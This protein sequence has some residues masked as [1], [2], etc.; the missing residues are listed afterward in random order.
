MILHKIESPFNVHIPT[1]TVPSQK[2]H[3]YIF[4]PYLNQALWMEHAAWWLTSL[5]RSF[6]AWPKFSMQIW[7]NDAKL[8]AINRWKRLK[9]CCE[10]RRNQQPWSNSDLKMIANK[11]HSSFSQWDS[12]ITV[13]GKPI[14][15]WCFCSERPAGPWAAQC[16]PWAAWVA[17]TLAAINQQAE[18]THNFL[19]VVTKIT[20]PP[21][22]TIKGY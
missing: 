1:V 22:A 21:P 4:K 6:T 13:T 5:H 14:H 17:T 8:R 9:L 3:M 7:A 20:P 15:S 12:R 2:Y 19:Q 11:F 18:H 16:E 10:A